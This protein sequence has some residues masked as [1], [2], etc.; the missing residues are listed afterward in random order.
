MIKGQRSSFFRVRCK[1]DSTFAIADLLRCYL[2]LFH[3]L[4]MLCMTMLKAIA[5]G[6]NGEISF[7]LLFDIQSQKSQSSRPSCYKSS[8]ES[9]EGLKKI[10]AFVFIESVRKRQG[11]YLPPSVGSLQY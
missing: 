9:I 4:M 3:Y 10:S 8:R 2:K 6:R 11:S 1:V 5:S 7:P